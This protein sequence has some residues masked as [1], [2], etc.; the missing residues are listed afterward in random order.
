[1]N[2]KD[3]AKKQLFDFF[4]ITTCVNFVMCI[5]GMTFAADT[6]LSYEIMIY[7]P[8]YGLFGTIPS[9]ILYTK[10]ELSTRQLIIRKILEF[11]C[12]EVLLI[13]LTFGGGNLRK[14]NAPIIA[15]FAVSVLAVV[16]CVN[17][18]GWIFNNRQ[19]KQLTKELIQYQ[20]SF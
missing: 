13:L 11:L 6:Q 15:S 16:G 20:N 2:L 19:A 17:V 8:L 7:P 3:F 12:L 10:R 5:M 4:I 1:M 18:V 14:E 9:W